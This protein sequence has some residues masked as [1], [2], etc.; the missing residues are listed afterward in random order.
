MTSSR[1]G[2]I[3]IINV[4]WNSSLYLEALDLRNFYLRKPLGLS[5][6]EDDRLEDQTAAHVV[7]TQNDRV[8][9]CVLGIEKND[10]IK[11]R[12]MVVH[13]E[14]QRQGIGSLLL[15][16]VEQIFID[17]GYSSFFLH[18]RVESL[19]FYL[20]NKYQPVGDTFYEVGILHQLMEKRID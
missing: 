16:K 17:R 11:I 4:P 9:G 2:K 5:F 10:R 19:N 20:K 12:Q 1:D 14:F 3:E 18:A 7:A 15:R 6:T 8:I 13:P